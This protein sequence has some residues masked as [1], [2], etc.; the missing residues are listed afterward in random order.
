MAM[1]LNPPR[2][3][4]GDHAE[5][6]GGAERR[7]QHRTVG[8]SD[9][10]VRFARQLRRRLTLP[11]VVLWQQLRKR[12]N[13]LR[14]RRQFPCEGYVIDF[15]CLERR[16]AI[17]VDGEAH[18]MGDRPQRDLRRDAAL[19]DAGFQ[20]RR[21]AARDVLD[22]LEGVMT[23]ILMTCRNRPLHRSAAPSGPPPR[24]GED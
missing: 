19:S 21:I 9:R 20:T 10:N 12:P 3:G 14:F 11:E 4:E 2:N 18:A 22:N 7:A 24:S 8:A 17:E 1:H 15:A 6:G 23:H 13:G 16:L 5:H